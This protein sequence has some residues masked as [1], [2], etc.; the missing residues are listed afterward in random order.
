M[1]YEWE[2]N[3]DGSFS[4]PKSAMGEFSGPNRR[5]SQ[6]VSRGGSL[7]CEPLIDIVLHTA[8]DE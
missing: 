3:G 1:F 2:R 6:K 8:L 7:N 5:T 4:V